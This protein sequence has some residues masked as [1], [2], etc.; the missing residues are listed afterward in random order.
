MKKYAVLLT[1]IICNIYL[2]AQ[3]QTINLEVGK[4]IERELKGGESHQ[5]KISIP[6]NQFLHL[7]VTQKGVDVIVSI[8]NSTNEK[9]FEIDSPNGTQGKEIVL[10]LNDTAGEYVLDVTSPDKTAPIGKYEVKIIE[11]R[12]AVEKDKNRLNGE[13]LFQAAEALVNQGTA[14]SIEKALPKYQESLKE[15]RIYGDKKE[16]AATLNSIGLAMGA[17]G[18]PQKAFESYLESVTLFE[19]IG[20]KRL[21]S[22]TRHNIGLLFKVN[23]PRKALNYFK[24]ALEVFRET[25]D[26][27]AEPVALNN[28][29]EC[30]WYLSEY[31]SALDAFEQSLI[32]WR[33]QK[34]VRDIALAIGNLGLVHGVLGDNV[35][36]KLYVEQSLALGS[37]IGDKR[38]QSNALNSLGFINQK[39]GDLTKALEF[40][41]KALTIRREIG[42][43]REAA[44]TQRNIGNIYR[45]L[46]QIQKA[47]ENY[48]ASL[49]ILR[50]AN[51]LIWTGRTLGSVGVAYVGLGNKAEARKAFEEALLLSQKTGNKSDE[52]QMWYQLAVLDKMDGNLI[53][54]ETKVKQSIAYAESMRSTL[55]NNE[56]RSGY[57]ATVQNFFELYTDILLQKHKL[58]PND[59]F[60]VA[61]FQNNERSRARSL[62]DLLAES[63]AKISQGVAPDLLNKRRELQEQFN[64]KNSILTRLL[65]AKTLDPQVSVL[66]QTLETLKQE[67]ERLQTQIRANNPRFA[68]LTQPQPLTLSDIQ[69]Q[70]LDADTILLEYSLG[71]EK[72]YLFVVTKDNLQTFEL[73]KRAEIEAKARPYFDA[74]TARN[75]KIKFET[76]EEKQRRIEKADAEISNLAQNLSQIILAPAQNL[77]TK[78][79]LLIVADGILQYIPFASLPLKNKQPLV[80]NYEIVSLPSAST[81]AVL[82]KEFGTRKPAPK[83]IAVLADPVFTTSDD[84]YKI[85]EARKK[86]NAPTQ[87]A[88]SAKTRGFEENELNQAADDFS[89]GE[90]GFDFARLPFTRKEAEAISTL[91]PPTAKKL[92]LDFSAN[93]AN[94]TNS[95]LSNYKIIHFAT[96]SFLNTRR[97]EL[98][99]I[100]LSLIDENG[101]PQNGFLRTD[102]IY[103]LNFPAELVVLSGCQTGLGK[104]IRGEGLIGLTRGFMYAGAKRVAVSLWDVNDE[105]TAELMARFYKEMLG[106]K[107]L[108]PA[109]ALRQA[110]LSMSKDKRWSNPYYW[111]GFILQGEFK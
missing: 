9:K 101:K 83:T 82:R 18:D 62:L 19:E 107:K 46:G 36:E 106:N 104:E 32:I 14:A 3:T 110:Q 80:T 66:R 40:Y 105:A 73:P 42:S 57:F 25:N 93:L 67:N 31:Q 74:L 103:N 53:E 47:L 87:I 16:I 72:S 89:Q 108:S 48:Q 77:L 37:S 56:S 90:S 49:K 79:R 1:I 4:P 111:A 109:A 41:E 27:F 96:H 8:L 43:H 34:N 88:V 17:V 44:V 94:A 38:G 26:K 55:F 23:D 78:K 81:L 15:W 12:G 63:N 24:S 75:K 100:V 29:G 85:L 35:K 60:D 102:Q 39:Q 22:R 52:A 76:A 5:F 71:K 45:E 65:S 99:G 7:E 10:F 64:V 92:S 68:N 20:D 98:S 70:V 91:T 30:Y 58:Q 86:G 84:R 69:Q 54:A 11:L 51:D 50:D 95:E 33:E 2:Y 21:A 6:A 13:K 97:P 61:A 28:V 59:K